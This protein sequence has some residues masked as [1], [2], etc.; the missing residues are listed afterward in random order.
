MMDTTWALAQLRHLYAQLM[1]GRVTDARS[2]ARG[3]LGPAITAIETE[4]MKGAEVRAEAPADHPF[5][6]G[7]RVLKHTG[8]YQLE[9]EVRAAFTTSRGKVRFVV[10][11]SP[12]FLH[13]YSEQNLR[14]VDAD[15]QKEAK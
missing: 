1:S 14:P 4:Q 10:E 13:I 6:I 8:D 9:G 11:H 7:Q 5:H 3:L 2:T 15:P 12:G